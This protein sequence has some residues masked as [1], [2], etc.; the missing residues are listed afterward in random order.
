MSLNWIDVTNL[1][2]NILLLLEREQL[3]WL[4]GWLP[5]P[6][7]AT[8]LKANPAVE[9]YIRHKN[10]ALNP[11]VDQVLP[12]AKS[13]ATPEGI[14][15]AEET[16]LRSI[17]DLVVYALDPQIYADLPFWGWDSKELSG[18]TDFRVKSVEDVCKVGDPMWVK[19]I[20]IDDRGRVKLSRRAAMREK[21][22]ETE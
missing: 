4:P 2:F 19:C 15:E 21:D 11:W 12:Q 13:D 1:S 7:F 10:P 17:N 8:A 22:A 6:A 18:L 20:G 9:W 14:R 16:I 3:S 5:E